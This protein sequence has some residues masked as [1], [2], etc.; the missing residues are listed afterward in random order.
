MTDAAQGSSSLSDLLEKGPSLDT[1]IKCLPHINMLARSLETFN[2]F[3]YDCLL[4]T[5]VLNY[6]SWFLDIFQ[7]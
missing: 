3:Y 2:L 1:D 6:K 7:E 5:I 4:K